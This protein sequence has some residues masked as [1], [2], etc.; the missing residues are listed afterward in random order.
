MELGEFIKESIKQLIDGIADAQNYAIDKHAAIN[1][2]GLLRTSE[3]TFI[4]VESGH[5]RP[6]PQV[7][8]FD[9][10]VSVTEGGEIKAGLGVFG[11]AVGLG[12]QAKNADSNSMSSRIKFSLPIMF[13]QQKMS[14]RR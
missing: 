10:L 7:I 3:Q 8:E 13:P 9:I 4:I 2:E 6:I 11:G 12:T 14:S 1:P 5:E